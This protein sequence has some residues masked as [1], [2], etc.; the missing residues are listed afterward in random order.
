MRTLIVSEGK[1]ERGG[2]LKTLVCRLA[3]PRE[4]ECDQDRL[5]RD[6]IHA[7]HG[8][9]QGYFKKAVRWMLHAEKLAYEA[10][11]L[12]VDEDGKS[13]RRDES[14]RA[15]AL[16]LATIRRALGV[17][18]R[19]FD[20]W[21]LADEQA[22]SGALEITVDRQPDP[23]GI[24]DPKTHCQQLLRGNDCT[25]SQTQLYSRVADLAN[26]ERV[27]QRCPMGFRPFAQRIREL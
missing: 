17:A 2:A 24:H 14:D 26:L 11:I 5:A 16:G 15:Q 13:Q 21:M 20:A 22:L 23:E 7:H 27:A 6:D 8:K 9:G 1:H 4:L 3:V 18:I 25:M 19:K 10:I 12:V